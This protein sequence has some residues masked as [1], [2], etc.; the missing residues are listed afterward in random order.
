MNQTERSGAGGRVQHRFA[1]G[2]LSP[3]NFLIGN[4]IST[5]YDQEKNLTAHPNLTSTSRNSNNWR[6]ESPHELTLFS[7][8]NPMTSLGYPFGGGNTSDSLLT[9]FLGATTPVMMMMPPG[10]NY[11]NERRR[12]LSGRE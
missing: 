9:N 7:D 6:G 12:S 1:S 11:S 2:S 10:G 4:Q 3:T 5:N 8:N